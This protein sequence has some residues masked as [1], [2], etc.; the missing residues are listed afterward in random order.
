MALDSYMF[1]FDKRV[2]IQI[3][4]VIQKLF[5]DIS[6]EPTL[7]HANHMYR[8][9]LE[10]MWNGVGAS[11]KQSDDF[12]TS[13]L[14]KAPNVKSYIFALVKPSELCNC[15]NWENKRISSDLGM[16][17]DWVGSGLGLLEPDLIGLWS[18]P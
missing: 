3:R 17:M 6:K 8:V 1:K 18:A 13:Y 15:L 4:I 14:F 5:R 2:W 11:I 9:E 10:S 16:E 12:F 7:M